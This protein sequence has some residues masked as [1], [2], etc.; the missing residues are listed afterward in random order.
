LFV[1]LRGRPPINPTLA[2]SYPA[3]P[4]PPK[5]NGATGTTVLGSPW[6]ALLNNA[7]VHT[8][9]HVVKS[10]RMLFYCAQ[11][12]GN[13]PAGAVIGAVDANGKETHAGAAM[14]DGTL[15]IRVAGALTGSLGWV[16]HGE[17]ERGWDFRGGWEEA[18]NENDD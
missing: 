15:F 8:E 6:L 7:A 18:W 3:S 11:H 9:A 4:A 2:M 12:Y 1:L 14:V 16:A 13:T 10:I 5:V 17:E